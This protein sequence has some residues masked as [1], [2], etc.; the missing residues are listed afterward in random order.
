VEEHIKNSEA[1]VEY[2]DEKKNNPTAIA[3][4]TVSKIGAA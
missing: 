3:V 1:S 2:G 4:I